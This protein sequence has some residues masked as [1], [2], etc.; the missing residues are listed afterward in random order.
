MPESRINDIL[1]ENKLRFTQPSKFNDPFEINPSFSGIKEKGEVKRQFDRQ[2][3]Q[4]VEEQYHQFDEIK[5]SMSY[6]T[7]LK[8][9]YIK[10]ESILNEI[11]SL[12][13]GN[14]FNSTMKKTFDESLNKSLGILSLT[15]KHDNLLMWSHYA[16]EHKGL[17]LEFDTNHD[18]FKNTIDTK[19]FLNRLY[20]VSYSEERPH[21]FL[22]NYNEELMFL[23]K[24]K[25]WTYEDEYRMFMPLKNAN[26]IKNNDI[27]LFKFPKK[28]LTKIYCGCNMLEENKNRIRTIIEEDIELSHIN[29][30]ETKISE[31][32][33]RL[34]FDE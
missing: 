7:F 34:D 10:K 21:E 30:V 22:S 6:S 16:N 31:K 24:S 27:F 18:F 19:N 9:A 8:I 13:D 28:I 32:Y 33:Y 14:L 11:V 2:F 3:E 15:T 5:R 12:I 26:E 23:T 20:K 1:I 25:E 17:V 4:I 29:V